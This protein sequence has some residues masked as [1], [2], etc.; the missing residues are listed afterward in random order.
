MSSSKGLFSRRT[1]KLSRHIKPSEMGISMRIK[2]FENGSKVI[3]MPRSTYN[4]SVPHPRYK[5][6]TAVV[7]GKRGDAYVV[8]MELS[9][10]TKRRLV[11]P[12]M[13]LQ[14]A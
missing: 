9:K 10:S 6:R 13:H 12:Q 7:L 4:R 2:E 14:R 8:E 5:G 11:V 1:R 3:I